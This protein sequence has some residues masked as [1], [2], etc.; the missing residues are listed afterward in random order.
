MTPCITIKQQQRSCLNFLQVI[1]VYIIHQTFVYQH[2][3]VLHY[4][5]FVQA[6]KIGCNTITVY[7]ITSNDFSIHFH[8]LWSILHADHLLTINVTVYVLKRHTG[9]L[10]LLTI[11]SLYLIQL[12]YLIVQKQHDTCLQC[13]FDERSWN[14]FLSGKF[15]ILRNNNNNHSKNLPS[16]KKLSAVLLLKSHMPP[17]YRNRATVSKHRFLKGETMLLIIC[18]VNACSTPCL[19]FTLYKTILL[20]L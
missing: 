19:W 8:K 13:L 20:T 15:K 18:H 11:A 7:N 17:L 3:R 2:D 10:C 9:I 16:F 5:Y 4:V 1:N 14:T 12:I 6:T